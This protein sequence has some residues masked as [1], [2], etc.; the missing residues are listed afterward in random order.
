MHRLVLND[1]NMCMYIC[2]YIYIYMRMRMYIYIYIWALMISKGFGVC[3]AKSLTIFGIRSPSNS[4]ATWI[5]LRLS[6]LSIGALGVL[7][8]KGLGFIVG[9]C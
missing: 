6:C 7:A 2:I 4:N 8:F 5:C 3:C 9:M 1:S